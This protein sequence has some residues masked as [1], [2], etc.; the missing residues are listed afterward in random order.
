MAQAST[1]RAGVVGLSSIGMSRPLPE[2]GAVLRTP[3]PHSHVAAH[4]ALL[5]T[6]LVAVCDISSEK[7]QSFRET[8]DD[9]FPRARTYSDYREMIDKEDL[10]IIQVATPDNR[11][12]DIVVDSADAGVK[13]IL[14]EKPL[15]TTL[16]DCDRMSAACE[17]NGALLS[18]DHTRRWRPIYHRARGA[19]RAGA[20]G[21]VM[22]IV[23]HQGG[24]RAML[25]RIGGHLIDGILFFAESDPDWV[26][27][28]LDEGFEDY[29]FY[30]GS[31]GRMP[32]KD[33]GGSGYVH[34]ENGVRA[35][36][37]ASKG[38]TTARYLEVIGESGQIDIH[39]DSI[40]LWTGPGKCERLA[41]D[42]HSVE[43]IAAALDELTRVGEDGGELISSGHEATKVVEI[44]V[45]FLRSQERGNVRV[46]LPLPRR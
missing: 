35:F 2:R 18:V 13:R 5:N 32:E 39:D 44:I 36:V 3:L 34:F 15:A 21:R 40:T 27:A 45:G 28:H 10:D 16:A 43:G 7:L 12:T 20:I 41:T 17:A 9:V 46:D 26:F 33:P 14:C 30:K 25:F 4:T 29:Y 11:H 37:N 22:R 24:P 8:W 23:A 6:Q 31:G 1:Y 19:I 42:S 38:Q